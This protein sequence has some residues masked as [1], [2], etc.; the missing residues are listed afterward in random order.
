LI[1][2]DTNIISEIMRA[3]PEARVI[4]WL[5]S[6]QASKLFLSSI[7]LAEIG[8]GLYILPDGKR[9]WNL[10]QRFDQFI[11]NAFETQIVDFTQD[12]AQVYARLMGERKQAG[13][14]MSIPDGQI[15]AIA[16]ANGYTIATRNIK[17]FNNCGLV[18]INPFT[19]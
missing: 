8:Y 14:P 19:V 10:Q 6:Q 2:L 11:K 12:S 15:A 3:K 4:K 16:L 13:N 17:D 1:V 9:K 18:L 5:N 7:T